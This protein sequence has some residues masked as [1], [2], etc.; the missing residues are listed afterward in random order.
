MV[1]NDPALWLKLADVALT[2]ADAEAGK[3]DSS[4]AA[5]LAATAVS[6]AMNA[7]LLSETVADRARAL[8]TLAHGLERREMWR[9]SIA[10]YRTSVALVDD[11]GLQKRLDAVVAQL[12]A[13]STALATFG[14]TLPAESLFRA[15]IEAEISKWKKL[16]DARKIEKQ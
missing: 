2:R 10:T 1:H 4:D 12:G 8:G 11:A 13:L 6:S 15:Y 9:E 16:I 3:S 7:F 14:R 5:D